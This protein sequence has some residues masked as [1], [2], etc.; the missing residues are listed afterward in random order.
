MHINELI[1]TLA[2]HGVEFYEAPY[3]PRILTVHFTRR[4][5]MVETAGSPV[6]GHIQ[7]LDGQKE[8]PDREVESL[9]RRLWLLQ[10]CPV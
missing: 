7:L 9:F 1:S 2:E 8:V 3:S 5:P 4:L 10:E 6:Y